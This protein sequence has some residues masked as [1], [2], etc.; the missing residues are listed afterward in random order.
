[1]L[2]AAVSVVYRRPIGAVVIVQRVR[3]RLQLSRLDTTQSTLT[4]LENA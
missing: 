4:Y 2:A 1:M 3:R